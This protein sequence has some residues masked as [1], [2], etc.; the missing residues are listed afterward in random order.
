MIWKKEKLILLSLKG[1]ELQ[2]KV[3]NIHLP[4]FLN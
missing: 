1:I 4:D 2:N 3:F